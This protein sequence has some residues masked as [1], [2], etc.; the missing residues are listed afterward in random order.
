[1]IDDAT[2]RARLTLS[3][4]VNRLFATVHP[5]SEPER[6]TAAVAEQVG[7]QLGRTVPEDQLDRLRR[8]EF[9]SA[10]VGSELLSAIAQCFG[11]SA[12]YLTT[13]GAA[14][15][16][17]DR[18]LELLATM[19]DANVASIALR[20]SDVDLTTLTALIHRADQPAERP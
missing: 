4:K 1:M 19:R 17:I 11:V 5:R 18:E 3:H 14:A 10:P 15:A 13:A 12:D 6:T 7:A 2:N 20:G 8:G 16:A 9:D